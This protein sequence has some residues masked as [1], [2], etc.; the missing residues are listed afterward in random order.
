MRQL[1]LEF[2]LTV[3]NSLRRPGTGGWLMGHQHLGVLPRS[4]QWAQVV[5]LISGGAAADDIAAATSKAAE[6][7]MIDASNDAAVRHAFWLLTQIPLAARQDDFVSTLRKLGMDV[8]PAP[9]LIEISSALMSAIDRKVAAS[10][11]RSD[12]GEMAQ[13]CAAESL[14]AVGGRELSDLFGPTSAQA[15]SALAGFATVKQFAILSRDYFSRLMRRH[16]SYYL[17]R[18]LSNHVGATKRFNS[19]RAHKA[20]ED[21]LDGHCREASRIIKEYSGEWFSK[22][23]YEGGIDP[24]K[25]GRFVHVA[26]GKVRDELR[27][28]RG[29]HA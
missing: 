4:K 28:R 9:S 8:G 12:F 18:E 17:S 16:L 25:A 21:A 7:S 14:Y 10:G 13:L 20:F 23:N 24:G 29:A 6:A 22:H 26:A 15:Q 19:V 3:T 27:Y 2:P 1:L 11:A 5:E